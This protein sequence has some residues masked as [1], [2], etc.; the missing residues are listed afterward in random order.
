MNK[1]QIFYNNKNAMVEARTPYE[2]QKIGGE[3]WRV[4]ATYKIAWLLVEVGGQ[5]VNVENQIRLG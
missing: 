1:Y 4:K 5:A 3:L 2:A